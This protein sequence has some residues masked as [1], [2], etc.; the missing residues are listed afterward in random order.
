MS[1]AKLGER[2]PSIDA[3]KALAHP[4]RLQILCTLGSNRLSVGEIEA[5][6]GITQPALSQQLRVL[7][8]ADLVEAEREAKQVFYCVHRER[9]EDVVDRIGN[10]IPVPRAK[11]A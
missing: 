8:D 7:R 5:A 9:L 1:Q 3:L 10:I 4:S 11:A 6:T 2:C